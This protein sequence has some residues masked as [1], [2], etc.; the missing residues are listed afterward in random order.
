[1]GKTARRYDDDD[2]RV[3]VDMNVEGMRRNGAP[4]RPEGLKRQGS[5]GQA[6]EGRGFN[7]YV[8]RALLLIVA[9]FSIGWIL[10]TLFATKVWLR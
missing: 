6:E 8:F 2:G 3:I 1:M 10:F 9:V 5:E 4:A 7:R